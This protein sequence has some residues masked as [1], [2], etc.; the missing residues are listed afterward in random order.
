VR[1]L[2]EEVVECVVIVTS[3]QPS[4]PWKDGDSS[5]DVATHCPSWVVGI[6]REDEEEPEGLKSSGQVPQQKSRPANTA[7]KRQDQH[8]SGDRPESKLDQSAL[9]ITVGSERL[10]DLC[11]KQA[12]SCWYEGKQGEQCLNHKKCEPLSWKFPKWTIGVVIRIFFWIVG[13][14]MVAHM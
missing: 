2:R 13:E 9:S 7:H 14:G 10:T 4:R 8:R 1:D 11:G 6:P 5:V 12:S 3:N